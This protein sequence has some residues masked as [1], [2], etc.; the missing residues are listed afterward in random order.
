MVEQNVN[1]NKAGA[2]N[3]ILMGNNLFCSL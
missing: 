2:V 3:E 1:R